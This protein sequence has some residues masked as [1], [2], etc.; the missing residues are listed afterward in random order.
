MVSRQRDERWQNVFAGEMWNPVEQLKANSREMDVVVADDSRVYR[1]LVED[2]LA[3]QKYH[4]YFASNGTEAMDLF[5]VHRPAVVI[6]DWEMPD[7]TGIELCGQIRQQQK[8]YTYLILLTSNTEKEQIVQGLKA[9]ADDYLTKPFHA[10]ELLAPVAVGCRVAAL[11]REI[12]GKN[13]LLEELA[14]TDSLTGL[15]NRRA[16]EDWATRQLSGAA[17][18]GF[19]VWIAIADLDNFKRVNDNYGHEAGDQVLKRFASIIRTYTRCSNFCGRLGGEEFLIVLSQTDRSGVSTAIERLR[20]NVEREKFDFAGTIV[21]VTAS[22]GVS[23][24]QGKKGSHSQLSELLRQAD[25][26]LY[27]AKRDG[28]NR[29]KFADESLAC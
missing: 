23:G 4:I 12:E 27:G 6:T 10:G 1:K 13:R 5:L 15:P 8:T 2:A 7:L 19:P 24:F 25:N 17:R 18:H 11:Y 16:A 9:G 29:V 28:K 26:A 20:Q 21:S 14:L 22:F 3:G